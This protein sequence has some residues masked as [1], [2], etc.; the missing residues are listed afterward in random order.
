MGI[1]FQVMNWQKGSMG[2]YFLAPKK[3]IPGGGLKVRVKA[4]GS[5]MGKQKVQPSSPQKIG[6]HAPIAFASSYL[7]TDTH[8]PFKT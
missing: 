8:A 2:T 5:V 3:L 1:C 6:T 7:K 4:G